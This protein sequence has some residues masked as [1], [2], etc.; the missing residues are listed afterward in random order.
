MRGK[1]EKRTRKTNKNIE[2]KRV[3]KS[4]VGEG[5]EVTKGKIERERKQRKSER[6]KRETGR[7]RVTHRARER[8]SV[9][10]SEY[11][12]EGEREGG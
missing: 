9:R 8:V 7:R 5:I 1:R 11:G 2:R 6:G 4:E 12:R 10:E 3:E